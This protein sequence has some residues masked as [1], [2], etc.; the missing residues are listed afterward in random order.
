MLVLLLIAAAVE[1]RAKTEGS[2]S[3]AVVASST[4][5]QSDS[6]PSNEVY[7]RCGRSTVPLSI[8]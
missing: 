4:W 6:Q 1:V 8:L 5:T 2:Y 7:G 3:R